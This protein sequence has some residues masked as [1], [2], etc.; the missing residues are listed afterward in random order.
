MR[1]LALFVVSLVA[2]V[3][4]AQTGVIKPKDKITLSCAQEKAMDG[5]YEVNGDGVVQL[6]FLGIV[7][8]AGLS[9][10]DAETRI[11]KLLSDERIVT[12]PQVTIAVVGA[13]VVPQ[14]P[15]NKE[16]GPK[17]PSPEK[18][19]TNPQR[20]SVFGA[21]ES[22]VDFEVVPGS[23]LG[24]ALAMVKPSLKADLGSVLLTR[25]DGSAFSFDC[26]DGAPD[27]PL[28]AGDRIEIP[29]LTEPQTI[30]VLGAVV[31]PGAIEFYPGLTVAD[32]IEKSGG[33]TPGTD[34]PSIT[35][36]R[37]GTRTKLAWPEEARAT[38]IQAYDA[39]EVLSYGALGNV[40]V[41]GSVRRPGY[42]TVGE[43]TTLGSLIRSAGGAERG[44]NLTRVAVLRAGEKKPSYF[45]YLAIEQGLQG[46]VP[47]RSGDRVHID[48]PGKRRYGPGAAAGIVGLAWL[49]LGR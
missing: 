23:T 26:R 22:K 28:Y 48:G 39:V 18:P 30:T 14:V 8:I 15:P 7:E 9:P 10:Q 35:L 12:N 36:V 37:K 2:M 34:G 6:P 5:E 16:P 42:Y 29:E 38:T 47:L 32:A 41:E 44:S 25:A 13:P 24:T 19:V 31:S 17:K 27:V 3:A 4:M 45:D 1:L 20:A 21:V 49:I 43:S 46:D 33:V 40:T 11:E